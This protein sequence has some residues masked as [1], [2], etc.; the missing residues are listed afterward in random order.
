V[1][2]FSGFSQIPQFPFILTCKTQGYILN[3]ITDISI[4]QNKKI[5]R[6]QDDSRQHANKEAGQILAVNSTAA[7]RHAAV[8]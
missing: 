5:Q 8:I 3:E 4:G 1:T 2:S 7:P 6:T